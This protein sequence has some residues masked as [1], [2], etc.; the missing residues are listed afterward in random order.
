MKVSMSNKCNC[1]CVELEQESWGFSK[2]P[3]GFTND[4]W[5]LL[6]SQSAVAPKHISWG[7]FLAVKIFATL[8][9]TFIFAYSI[10]NYFANDWPIQLWP[11]YLT[12][13]QVVLL[14]LHLS[15]SLLMTVIYRNTTSAD[16]SLPWWGKLAWILQ[17]LAV[18]IVPAVVANFWTLVWDGST[19]TL[20]TILQ[21][22]VTLVLLVIDLSVSLTPTYVKHFYQPGIFAAIY[23][24]FNFVYVEAGGVNEDDEPYVYAILSWTTD[25]K[26]AFLVSFFS[27]FLLGPL[28]YATVALLNTEWDVSCFQPNVEDAAIEVEIPVHQKATE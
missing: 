12:H 21:H 1:L 26:T 18:G 10:G 7:T 24:I 8:G 23:M 22:A 5:P 17:N 13:W 20:A 25:F 27:C 4:Q 11:I 28:I 9:A 19:P 2:L 16:R 3:Y 15:L 14:F 6:W